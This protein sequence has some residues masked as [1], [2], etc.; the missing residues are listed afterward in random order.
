MARI[1]TFASGKGGTGKS[2]TVANLGTA[3][4]QLGKRVTILD[5]D[6]TMANL[7]VMLGLEDQKIT[8]HDVLAGEA[9]ISQVIY[10]GPAGMRIVPSSISLEGLRRTKLERLR[11]AV[12]GLAERSEILL[13]DSPAGLDRDAVTALTMGEEMILVVTP[14][15]AS[16]SDALKTKIIAENLGV[17]PIG[18]VV[19]RAEDKRVDLSKEEIASVLDLPVL[20][21]IPED[22][23]VGRSTAFC[24]PVV[25]HEPTS[26][27][28]QAFKKLARDLLK[29]KPRAKTKK[30]AG[31]KRLARGPVGERKKR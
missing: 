31:A 10:E 3:I 4:A 16:I 13:I 25:V 5:A 12:A 17:K 22:P 19:T 23:E 24:E 11:K 21:V 30:K 8:L 14:D 26:P 27:S 7:G 9:S 15:I 29:Q 20:A 28:A 2:T 6:I 1:I 18:I